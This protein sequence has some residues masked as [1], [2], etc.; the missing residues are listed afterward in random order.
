MCDYLFNKLTTIL[1]SSRNIHR[2]ISMLNRYPAIGAMLV[3]L[4]IITASNSS[5]AARHWTITQRQQALLAEINTARKHNQLTLKET[6]SL[7]DEQ[8]KIVDKEQSMKDKNGGK[9]SQKDMTS[10]ERSLNDLSNKLHK[11]VLEKRVQ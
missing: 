5:F 6:N 7:I 1:M 10:L 9:L 2:R 8:K 3:S 11:K 4:L